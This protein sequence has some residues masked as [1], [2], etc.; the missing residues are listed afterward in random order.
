MGTVAWKDNKTAQERRVTF[1]E[2]VNTTSKQTALCDSATSFKDF[3]VSYWAW[4]DRLLQTG[5]RDFVSGSALKKDTP[6]PCKE[7]STAMMT[8]APFI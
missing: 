1:D 5:K 2:A 4:A 3:F 7:N 8:V 6:I